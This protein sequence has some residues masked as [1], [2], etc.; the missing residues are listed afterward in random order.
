LR[1]SAR[2]RTMAMMATVIG[3]AAGIAPAFHLGSSVRTQEGPAR[4]ATPPA[5]VAG[6]PG[7][8]QPAEESGAPPRGKRLRAIVA[9]A[10]DD[11]IITWKRLIK[12]RSSEIED[13]NLRFV[14]R[15]GPTNCYGLYSGEGPAYCSGNHTVFVGTREASRLMARFGPRAE[16]G[17]AFLIG[18]EMGHHI[19]NIFGRFQLLG[20][21]I[22]GAPARR[23]YLVRHFELEADCYAGVW[24]HASPAWAK[25]ARFRSDM[26]H[27]LASIGDDAILGRKADGSAPP[28]GLHGTS[29]QR[30]HWF[31]RG[32][33]SGDWHACNA[34]A[35]I[36]P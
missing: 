24:I 36:A 18:H 30:T 29:E 35:A 26:M 33:K 3:T 19:Q 5:D 22:A 32:A 9:H 2:T 1:R 13:I 20:Y 31:V 10:F 21:L 23:T 25:S 17:I 28:Q 8:A 11:S 14:T 6:V 15:L 7:Q 16:A 12:P 27:V 34:F 4:Q